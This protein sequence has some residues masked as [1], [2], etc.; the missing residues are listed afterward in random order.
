ML[1]LIVPL[2]LF[3]LETKTFGQSRSN[4]TLMKILVTIYRIVVPRVS[5]QFPLCEG[6]LVQNFKSHLLYVITIDL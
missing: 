4:T 3:E 5:S 6:E 1:I 2:I